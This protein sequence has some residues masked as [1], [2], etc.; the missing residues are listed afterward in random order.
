MIS[1]NT[2][3]DTLSKNDLRMSEALSY[4]HSHYI[5]VHTYART[6]YL[7]ALSLIDTHVLIEKT[8][9]ECSCHSKLQEKIDDT[10]KLHERA[11]EAT[12]TQSSLHLEKNLCGANFFLTQI[13]T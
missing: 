12:M 9:S 10:V 7:L 8:Q 4:R 3:T 13:K 11:M 1:T 6:V 2:H 5:I